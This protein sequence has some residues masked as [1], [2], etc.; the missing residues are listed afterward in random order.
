MKNFLKKLGRGV[1]KWG[2]VAIGVADVIGVPYAGPVARAI[3][4]ARNGG[5]PGHEQARRALDQ[6][7]KD[8]PDALRLL[9]QQLGC[10]IP[11]EAATAYMKDQVEAH[12]R[13]LKAL[14]KLEPGA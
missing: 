10:D 12:Y 5:G 7:I 4:A 11:E 2:P 14:G 6:V 13:L 8:A 1:A 3:Q 9:E